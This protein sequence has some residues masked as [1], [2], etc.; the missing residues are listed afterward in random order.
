M[1][2]SILWNET[3]DWRQMPEKKLVQNLKSLTNFWSYLE[4]ELADAVRWT[5]LSVSWVLKNI[6]ALSVFLLHTNK[7][8]RNAWT[9][10]VL[11]SSQIEPSESLFSLSR[12]CRFGHAAHPW[13]VVMFKCLSLTAATWQKEKLLA[14]FGKSPQSSAIRDHH[15]K[16]QKLTS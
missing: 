8:C 3:S 1:G 12:Q 13:N 10:A 6:D 5:K 2:C 9:F 11:E 14:C 15:T 16:Q 4:D 7:L